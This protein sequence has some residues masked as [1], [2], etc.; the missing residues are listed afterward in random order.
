MEFD[1]EQPEAITTSV[2]IFEKKNVD[3]LQSGT[4][5]D[6]VRSI[7]NDG[8]DSDIESALISVPDHIESLFKR[9]IHN[10]TEQV[11]YPG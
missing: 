10:C 8:N 5:G 6:D 9:S 4:G 7:A 11:L 1:E 2:L 3:S